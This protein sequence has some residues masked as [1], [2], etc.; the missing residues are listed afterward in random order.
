MQ[1]APSPLQP[2]AGT[3]TH[4]NTGTDGGTS[5][6]AR[7][8]LVLMAHTN[9]G[10]TTLARTLLGQDVG[11]VRDAAHVTRDA[12]AYPLLSTAEGDALLLWDTPGLGDSARL[13]R[14]LS[15]A[16]NPIQWF[17]SQVW[18]RWTDPTFHLSQQALRA[19]RDNA[20]VVLYILN[21]T[22]SPSATGYLADELK[23]L[24]WMDKPVL[25]L[26]NQTGLAPAGSDAAQAE[27]RRWREHLRDAPG[28][29]GV[30]ALDAFTRCWVH[31]QAFFDALDGLVAADK[32]PA[33]RRLRR[34]WRQRNMARFDASM[35]V[36]ARQVVQ[37]ALRREAAS[38]PD[39]EPRL[40]GVRALLA[41]RGGDAARRRGQQALQ[42]AVEQGRA[43]TTGE[44]L[45][46][47][48]LLDSRG[49]PFWRRLEQADLIALTPLDPLRVGAGGA[50][51]TG[52]VSGLKADLATGGLTM[53]AGMLLGALAGAVAF[54]VGAEGFNRARGVQESS[55]RLS[56]AALH[57]LLQDAL[58]KYLA[59]AHFGRGRGA[60]EHDALPA[61]W[62]EELAR[63]EQ[64]RAGTLD[65]VFE[66]LRSG[67]MDEE[68]AC[69][70]FQGCAS[71][72]A[73]DLLAWMYPEAHVERLL[74]EG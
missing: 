32:Q 8:A 57:A 17:L 37:A 73:L 70:Q 69:M 29:R 5:A 7:I 58:L 38:P 33:S 22:E 62:G 42:Q 46:L 3:G 21:A 26:L 60:F 66:A 54:A 65:A 11:E 30:L 34:D 27:L 4:T 67:E 53:G 15:G 24:A 16:S 61:A 50:I 35:A 47:H 63:S 39:G 71:R 49:H 12:Q 64:A 52:A 28:V 55:L 14:R 44:L 36:I 23:L 43:H 56:N 74:R 2:P 20:D 6:A 40:G 10:K 68:A 18:D 1:A 31:E 19:T 72:L 41:P 9:V 13:Y 59:V 48:G 25:V 51:A 45:R